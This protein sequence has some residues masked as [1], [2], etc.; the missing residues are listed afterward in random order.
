MTK[1]LKIISII[2][3]IFIALV[4]LILA[5]KITLNFRALYYFDID[6]LKITEIT[7]LTKEE[8]KENYDVLIDYLG[9]TNKNKLDFPNLPMSE[10]GEIHF[11]DVKSIFITLDYVLI[12]SLLISITGI[13]YL[14]K[15]KSYH[16]YKYSSLFLFGLPILLLIPLLIDFDTFFTLFHK[17]AF[18]NDYWLFDPDTDP[19]ITLL[20]Q[21]FFMHAALLILIIITIE[22]LLL[23]YLHRFHIKKYINKL[24]K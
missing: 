4:L 19:I 2:T 8:I 18:R 21:R 3:S 1:K 5:V 17:I 24:K 11:E 16:F 13:L 23:N 7:D 6:Y 10:A 14:Y 22:S 9:S 15:Q 12:F 20:P